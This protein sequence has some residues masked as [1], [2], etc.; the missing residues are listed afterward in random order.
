MY[1]MQ[2]M[3]PVPRL[4][5]GHSRAL[6]QNSLDQRPEL[7]DVDPRM[8]HGFLTTSDQFF[9]ADCDPR[10]IQ[11]KED[12]LPL[13][14]PAPAGYQN[15]GFAEGRMDCRAWAQEDGSSTRSSEQGGRDLLAAPF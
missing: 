12:G 9:S 11:A 14:S 13:Q 8:E 6:I 3:T 15:A 2:A 5:N 4:P 7:V 1:P 10:L